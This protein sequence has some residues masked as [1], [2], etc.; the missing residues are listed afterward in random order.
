MLLETLVEFKL[1]LEGGHEFEW[2]FGDVKLD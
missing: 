1:R 2:I